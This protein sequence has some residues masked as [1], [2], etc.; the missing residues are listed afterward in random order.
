MKII[1]ISEPKFDKMAHYTEKM[2][3]YGGR[4]MSCISEIGD[5]YGV[6]YREH[7]GGDYKRYG[8]GSHMDDRYPY[9]GGYGYPRVHYRHDD[10]DWDD[11]EEMMHER[12]SR[13]RMRDSMGRY[14]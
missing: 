1:E 6:S 5:E 4:L 10:E 11:D 8:D 9:M 7:D 14:R 12:R 2:L 13:R 3:K